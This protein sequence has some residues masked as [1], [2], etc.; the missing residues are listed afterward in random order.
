MT[1]QI[2]NFTGLNEIVHLNG[3]HEQKKAG[4]N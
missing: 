1:Q 2:L 3:F 4:I